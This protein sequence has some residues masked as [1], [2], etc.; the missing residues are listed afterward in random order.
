M[1]IL[2]KKTW[3]YFLIII[4]CIGAY[5]ISKPIINKKLIEKE[6][7]YTSDTASEVYMVW[8]TL[9]GH[10]P[11][12]KLWPPDSYTKD[13][14][15]W[16]KMSNTNNEFITTLNLP[17]GSYI[18][19]WMVQTR[20]KNNHVT[21]VWDSGGNNKKY[22]ADTISYSGIIK[23]GYFIFLAGFLPLMLF[24]LKQ[25][26]KSVKTIDSLLKI[27]GYIPQ[28]DTIRAIAV[29]LVILH[30][31]LPQDSVLNIMPNGRLGVNIFFVLSGFLI[32]G[33][34]LREKDKAEVLKQK[35]KTIFR[36]FYIRRSLRIFPIYYLFLFILWMIH[37]P[38]VQSDGSYFYTYTSNYLFYSQEFF[39]ARTAHLWSLG[40]EEQFYLLWPWLIVFSSRKILPYLILLFLVIGI[41]SNYIITGKG[42]WSEILTIACF[43]AFAIG[44]FL[45]WL[46]AYRQDIITKFQPLFKFFLIP[47]VL[48]FILDIFQISVI[49]TRT[50]HSLLAIALIFI[51]LFKIN[52]RPVNFILNNKW[53]IRLGKISYGIYLYHL[54]IPELRMAI[55]SV[56]TNMGYDF[57]FTQAMPEKFKEAWIFIQNFILLLCIASL[58]WKF[59]EKPINKLKDKFTVRPKPVLN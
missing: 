47:V 58:S 34:L 27:N 3:F 29:L 10:L 53:L 38:S 15:I 56:F 4:C 5:F 18:Y 57:M 13:A 46:I 37:D 55:E 1:Q 48:L 14:M 41:S 54:V 20:D 44:G 32:T 21:E 17:S 7:L 12:E 40:V 19:Y 45:S 23:P 50:I 11:V 6:I 49:P 8:G 24:Y 25:R 16:T 26:N 22:F 42:W 59:I 51:C 31:W 9:E 36:N 33:I 35:K 39:P 52:N 28:L 43:D 2:F 30:H